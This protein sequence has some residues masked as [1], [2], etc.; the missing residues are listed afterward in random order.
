[1][2]GTLQISAVG[3]DALMGLVERQAQLEASASFRALR[4]RMKESETAE[5]RLAPAMA[6]TLRPYQNAGARWLCRLAHWGAGA[7]LA[8]ELWVT[9]YAIATLES[10]TLARHRFATLIID[11]AQA[12]KNATTD[13]ARALRDLEADWRLSLTGTPIENRLSELWSILRVTSPGLLGSW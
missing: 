6:A 13:R 12:V 3:S 8:G 9:S 2:R 1:H 5:P 10:E 7:V 4:E 11:E